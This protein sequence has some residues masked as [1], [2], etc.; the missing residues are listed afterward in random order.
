ML[1]TEQEFNKVVA[2]TVTVILG[3]QLPSG[4]RGQQ[5]ATLGCVLS[6]TSNYHLVWISN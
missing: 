3:S 1:S 2:K 5:M 4:S 6:K